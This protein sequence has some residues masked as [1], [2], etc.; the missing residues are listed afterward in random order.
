MHHFGNGS[1]ILCDNSTR[2]DDEFDF[3]DT[4]FHILKHIFDILLWNKNSRN[5]PILGAYVEELLES[6]QV[7]IMTLIRISNRL[8][9]LGRFFAIC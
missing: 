5:L 8:A 6:Y 2:L 9:I 7:G 1:E 3:A 4:S